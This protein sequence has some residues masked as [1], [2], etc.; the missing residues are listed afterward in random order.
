MRVKVSKYTIWS[1]IKHSTTYHYDNEPL[2]FVQLL[3]NSHLNAHHTTLHTNFRSKQWSFSFNP[4]NLQP[5]HLC[6]NCMTRMRKC[7]LF[8]RFRDVQCTRARCTCTHNNILFQVLNGNGDEEK[9]VDP[10][11]ITFPIWV[12]FN[13]NQEMIIINEMD[14]KKRNINTEPRS[15]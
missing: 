11:S 4:A 12:R 6:N 1:G 2:S 5:T 13:N 9:R 3:Q 15:Y 8:T 7:M 14:G 10:F